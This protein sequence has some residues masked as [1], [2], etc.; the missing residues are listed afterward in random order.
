MS[1]EIGINPALQPSE[2]QLETH[3]SL[4][5]NH[6]ENHGVSCNRYNCALSLNKLTRPTKFPTF[7]SQE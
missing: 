4:S 6:G 1:K 2:A 7:I 5:Q 3:P